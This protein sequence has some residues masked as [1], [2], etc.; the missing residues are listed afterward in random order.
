MLITVGKHTGKEK[1]ENNPEKRRVFKSA[2]ITVAKK[3]K[4]Y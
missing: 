2:C 3:I 1:L 4:N